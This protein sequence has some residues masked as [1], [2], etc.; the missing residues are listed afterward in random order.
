MGGGKEAPYGTLYPNPSP[1]NPTTR[2]RSPLNPH[3]SEVEGSTFISHNV[4]IEWYQKVNIPQ[5]RGIIVYY[6]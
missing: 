1:L 5:N 6:Y 2:T 3:S 4:L